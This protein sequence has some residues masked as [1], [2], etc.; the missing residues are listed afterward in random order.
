[1]KN[2][3]RARR[4]SQSST[5]LD[6]SVDRYRHFI[7]MIVTTQNVWGLYAD[8][9]AVGATSQGQNAL[10]L[11][12]ERSLAQLCQSGTWAQHEPTALSLENFIFRMLPY[13]TKEKVLLS[14]MMTPDGKSV[15]LEPQKVLMD[16]K[17]YLY[18]I[19]NQYP[20]FF[21]EN[22]TVPLPRK[23]RLNDM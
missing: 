23:I 7:K 18:D 11:W 6:S 14:I 16:I 5:P 21:T 4:S 19:Y 8:G 15:F 20:A 17:T 2:P 3:Y 22:P 9:W 13:T 12:S 1:M 10:P